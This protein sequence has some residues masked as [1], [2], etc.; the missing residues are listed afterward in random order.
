MQGK[1]TLI[2]NPVVSQKHY[3]QPPSDFVVS[4][5]VA[6]M[7]QRYERYLQ[8]REP[9]QPMANFR[10][11]VLKDSAKQF[12]GKKKGD[13]DRDKAALMY[14][15]CPRVLSKL[16]YL[17]GNVGDPVTGRKATVAEQRSLT[18]Q[19]VKWLEE[20]VKKLIRRAGEYAADPQR[21]R[22]QITM[23]VLPQL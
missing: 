18:P 2:A 20:V 22:Q 14:R 19:E 16:G 21:Q 13:K 9:L 8:D 10:L 23:G 3:P 1:A 17:T 15:V 6:T 12:P 5:H 7:W 4:P 11:T